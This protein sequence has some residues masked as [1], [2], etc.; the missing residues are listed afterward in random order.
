MEDSFVM[1]EGVSASDESELSPFRLTTTMNTN[2]DPSHFSLSNRYVDVN[3][4]VVIFGLGDLQWHSHLCLLISAQVWRT[5]VPP[6]WT[7]RPPRTTT[8]PPPTR[9]WGPRSRPCPPWPSRSKTSSATT[10]SS[11]KTSQQPLREPRM[12]LRRR[13]PWPTALSSGA[14]RTGPCTASTSLSIA[15]RGRRTT[16]SRTTTRRTTSTVSG[17]PASW[18]PRQPRRPSLR[19]RIEGMR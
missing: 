11:P 15:T 1:G 19:P 10:K 7:L 16:L 8:T 18:L 9:P 3:V 14:P 2:G 4:I 13:P 5:R 12:L 17:A 6:A